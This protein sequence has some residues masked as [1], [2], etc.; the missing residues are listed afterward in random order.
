LPRR[1]KWLNFRTRSEAPITIKPRAG[2]QGRGITVS[3]ETPEQIRRA[4]DW[5]QSYHPRTLVQETID[6]NAYRLLVIDYRYVAAVKLAPPT[7][8][9]DGEPDH[10]GT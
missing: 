4:F 10:S 1:K 2:S 7:V 8:V 6:G 3:P 9:G 5:A